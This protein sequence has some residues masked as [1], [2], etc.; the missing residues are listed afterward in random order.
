MLQQRSFVTAQ[1]FPGEPN[2]PLL[3][4]G[5]FSKVANEL[6]GDEPDSAVETESEE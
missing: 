3:E 4:N 2:G 1:M 5:S 6:D